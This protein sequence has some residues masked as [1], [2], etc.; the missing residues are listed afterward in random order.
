[1]FVNIDFPR[2]DDFLEQCAIFCTHP[3]TESGIQFLDNV[4]FPMYRLW[5]TRDK[6]WLGAVQDDAWKFAAEVWLNKR[7]AK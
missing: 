6:F 2:L 7:A 3:N 5:E 1:M 4:C